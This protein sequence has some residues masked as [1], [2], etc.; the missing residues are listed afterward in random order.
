MN[1]LAKFGDYTLAVTAVHFHVILL[2]F[3]L[4]NI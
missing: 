2:R 4:A 3:F 1:T